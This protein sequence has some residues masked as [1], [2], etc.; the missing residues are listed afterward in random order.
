MTAATVFRRIGISFVIAFLAAT[1]AFGIFRLFPFVGTAERWTTDY[2]I[3]TVTAPEPQHPD[4]VVAAI[5]EE[6]LSSFPYRSPIDRR[7]LAKTIEAL[8][9]KGA[10]ALLIDV[11]FDQETEEDKD[12]ELRAALAALEIPFAI[13]YSDSPLYVTDE[14]RAYLEEFVAPEWR[15]LADIEPD[16]RDG[17]IRFVPAPRAGH[18]GTRLASPSGS[19]LPSPKRGASSLGTASPMPRHRPSAR[20]P[21]MP[22][23]SCPMP[24]SRARSCCWGPISL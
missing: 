19:A 15:G 1:V 24:G 17:T 20:S 5:N 6:T 12:D 4:I 18:D 14:Q 9:A 22:C 10:K 3:A 11:L 21:R 7:F 8:A 13:S 2:R 16:I 23:L